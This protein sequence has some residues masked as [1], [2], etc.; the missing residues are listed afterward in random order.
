MVILALA[1]AHWEAGRLDLQIKKRALKIIEDGGSRWRIWQQIGNST[2][3][4]TATRLQ[5]EQVQYRRKSFRIIGLPTSIQCH[6]DATRNVG[7]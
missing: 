2:A 6:A 7:T 3:S 1:A 4:A 5:C